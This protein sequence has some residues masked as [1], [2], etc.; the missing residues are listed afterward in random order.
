MK[1]QNIERTFLRVEVTPE[2][3][4]ELDIFCDA[5][6]EKISTVSRIALREFMANHAK[7]TA[8]SVSKETFNQL[9]EIIGKLE[10]GN[11][12]K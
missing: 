7:K 10:D 6:G 1:K 11:R 2:F 9:K 5:Y 8:S 12:P 4:A 3:K